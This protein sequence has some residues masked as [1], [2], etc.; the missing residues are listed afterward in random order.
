MGCI[1]SSNEFS[2]PSLN[3]S[4][5]VSS[6]QEN[7]P[8]LI[9]IKWLTCRSPFKCSFSWMR[10]YAWICAVLAVLHYWEAFL[11]FVSMQMVKTHSKEVKPSIWDSKQLISY[12]PLHNK[13]YTQTSFC[14]LVR[15]ISFSISNYH[16]FHTFEWLY[17]ISSYR[18]ESH[19][20]RLFFY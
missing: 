14:S 6:S 9:E 19:I 18:G 2:C 13:L 15:Y 3:F 16:K 12:K 7:S 8:I 10:W 20:S 17:Q 5:C 11:W 1:L 4:A